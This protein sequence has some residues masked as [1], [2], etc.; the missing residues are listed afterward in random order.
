MA[1]RAVR[2]FHRAGTR[3]TQK[4]IY[5]RPAALL[6]PARRDHAGRSLDSGLCAGGPALVP[7]A[8][9]SRSS[10]R[11]D[12]SP[13][14]PVTGNP[15]LEPEDDRILHKGSGREPYRPRAA[16]ARRWRPYAT[17]TCSRRPRSRDNAAPHR[18]GVAKARSSTES[19]SKQQALKDDR[20]LRKSAR[21]GGR[22]SAAPR[23]APMSPESSS[24]I[25]ARALRGH[26]SSPRS[27]S[28]SRTGSKSS[29]RS[30]KDPS[31]GIRQINI[32]G[33][34]QFSDGELRGGW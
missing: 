31:P 34:E 24:S 5:E 33:N 16:R 10:C 4:F 23:R 18:R 11:S 13:L 6:C 30:V 8:R 22:S 21:A 32:L 29:T 2:S 25:A 14:D 17:P 15:R 26:G 19:C 7:S 27:S 20:S 3:D 28:S 9:D 12:D 1:D